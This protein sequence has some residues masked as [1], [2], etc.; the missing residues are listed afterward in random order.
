MRNPVAI[1]SNLFYLFDHVVVIELENLQDSVKA[2]MLDA[3]QCGIQDV[4]GVGVHDALSLR[5][6]T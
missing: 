5:T 4:E 1:P 2:P 3:V 6:N